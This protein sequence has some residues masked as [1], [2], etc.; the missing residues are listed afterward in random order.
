MGSLSKSDELRDT[1]FMIIYRTHMIHMNP[2]YDIYKRIY[3][4]MNEFK[5]HSLFMNSFISI[6]EDYTH[7]LIACIVQ[8]TV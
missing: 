2:L 3:Y 8:K 4:L 1:T 6:N 5:Q 7:S